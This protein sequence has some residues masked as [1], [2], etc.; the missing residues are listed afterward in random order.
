[1]RIVQRK[2]IALKVGLIILSL[3]LLASCSEKTMTDSRFVLGT[4]CTI[5]IN[6]SDD[7][8]LMSSAFDLLY[9]IDRSISRFDENS[10]VY[11]INENAGKEAVA[12]PEDI[13][14]L[15]KASLEM[16][17]STDGV[18]NPAIGPLSSLWGFGTESARVPEKSEIEAVLPLVDYHLVT[19]SEEDSSVF[20]E[21]EGMALD[22]GAVGKGWACD[23]LRAF[24][25]EEGVESALLN[26]GGNIAVIGSYKD[27]EPWKIG[28]Q[29]PFEDR[30]GGNIAVIGSYKD[31]EPWK[32]GIQRPFEDRGAYFTIVS[33]VDESVVV[34]GGYQRYIEQDGVFYH[35][36]LSSRT[37]YPAE[38]DLVSAAVITG[39]STLADMLSTTLFASGSE[40]A[41]E[42][43]RRFKVRT[44]LLTEDL[45]VID[46]DASEGEVAIR[47]E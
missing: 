30:G 44:I 32:I 25:E 45:E 20:L 28:I 43:A 14:A 33:V 26:L 27:G 5:T 3:L 46:L 40:K 11:K 10:W 21:K 29:R 7:E 6:G 8:A 39:S 4:V 16:A 41:E 19:L 47:E 15:I 36:I 13:F 22:L 1:M 31:G 37:G 9:E 35:H 17:E 23:K 38:T 18:F 42:I 2:G 34:S 24:L 12:V